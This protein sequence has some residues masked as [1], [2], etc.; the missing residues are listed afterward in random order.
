MGRVRG[1]LPGLEVTRAALRGCRRVLVRRWLRWQ[2]VQSRRACATKSGNR[3]RLWTR[4]MSRWLLQVVGV[5]HVSQRAPS[6][7][8]C[9]SRWQSAQAVPTCVKTSAAVAGAA[10]RPLRAP[11]RAGSPSSRGGSWAASRPAPTSPGRGTRRSRSSGPRAA[12]RSCP[13]RAGSGRAWLRPARRRRRGVG[14][15]CATSARALRGVAAAARRG[16]RLVADERPSVAG[17][18][19]VAAGAG[20]P[21]VRA[22]QPEARVAHVVERR[23][24][25]ADGRVAALARRRAALRDELPLVGIAVARRAGLREPGVADGPAGMHAAVAARAG[26]AGVRSVER[27]AGAAVVEGRRTPALDL[28]ARLAAARRRRSGRAPR[29]GDRRGSRSSG[30]TRGA[31]ER[32]PRRASP[33]A[34]PGLRWQALQATA[35]WPPR[36]GKAVWACSAGPKR[37]GRKPVTSWQLSQRP[38]SARRA[39]SPR[40]AS[41]WQSVQRA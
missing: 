5:W 20:E 24:L 34:P 23:A 28:V 12:S 36:S 41:R 22:V 8:R 10:G 38:P 7:P 40:C 1:L 26:H 18:A 3:L 2:A 33:D 27:E 29:D 15:S 16:Q 30:S 4:N 37:A 14:V 31:A 35:R 32:A 13:G 25:E 9:A 19:L 6:S 21:G 11:A 39:S 17:L